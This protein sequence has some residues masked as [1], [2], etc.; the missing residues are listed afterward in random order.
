MALT[1]PL[2]LRSGASR[3]RS[4][5]ATLGRTYLAAAAVTLIG[6]AGLLVQ[7][8]AQRNDL[9][10]APIAAMAGLVTAASSVVVFRV[11]FQLGW[12]RA[13][14]LFLGWCLLGF[15]VILLDK[16][17]VRRLLAEPIRLASNHMSPA[18]LGWHTTVACPYCE[19]PAYLALDSS[20]GYARP[21]VRPAICT[22]CMRK[23][24]H[25]VSQVQA[26]GP[27]LCWVDKL[28]R[29]QRWDIVVLDRGAK[30]GPTVFRLVGL[31]EEDIELTEEGVFV[32]GELLKPPPH[33]ASVRFSPQIVDGAGTTHDV[34]ASIWEL[35]QD[36]A[37]VLGE[38]TDNA[39]DSRFFGAVPVANLRGVVRL[40]Y[41]PPGRLGWVQ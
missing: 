8:L 1:T 20:N 15:A 7:N 34:P 29:P 36:Q 32:N 18:L 4:P 31:P 17:V 16:V 35:N 10:L 33:L 12:R 14:G 2:L 19:L 22:S 13:I 11:L 25:K 26:A 30:Q 40:R 23:S 27:D 21:T 37:V 41:W 24:E 3:L 6:W 28:S 39:Q 9:P 5:R 38:F